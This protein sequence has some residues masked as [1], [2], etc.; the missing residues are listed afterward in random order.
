LLIYS[1]CSIEFE[2]NAG[3]VAAFLERHPELT[4][5]SQ[6]Q[7]IPDLDTDGAFAAVMKKKSAC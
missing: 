4:L 5:V 3:Q 6:R 1:T 2:E 7:L